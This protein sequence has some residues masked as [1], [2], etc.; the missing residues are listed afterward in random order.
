MPPKPK[1]PALPS[2]TQQVAEVLAT[3]TKAI[4][5]IV[6]STPESK[7]PIQKLIVTFLANPTI[8]ELH[9]SAQ[10]PAPSKSPLPSLLEDIK[11]IKST[12]ATLQKVILPSA[13]TG[14]PP[15][16]KTTDNAPS[17]PITGAKGKT[18]IPT[19][20][21]AAA[22]PPHPSIVVSLHNLIWN[23]GRPSPA[24]LCTRINGALKPQPSGNDQ[25]HISTTRW[26]VRENV[27][28]TGG[29][30]T[31]AQHLQQAALTISQY[32]SDTYPL[33]PQVLPLLDQ[34]IPIGVSTDC[35]ARMPDECHAV[36]VLDNPSYASLNITQKPSW[37]CNPNSYPEGAVSSLV[38]VFEH[39]DSS[40]ARDL[41]TK[42]V[43]Y[44]FGHCATLRKWKQRPTTLTPQ[45][46]HANSTPKP[47]ST[48]DKEKELLSAIFKLAIEDTNT[49]CSEGPETS[50][51]T[52]DD[53]GRQKVGGGKGRDRP[54]RT[55]C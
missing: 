12:L 38:V 10:T 14:K 20:A 51:N 50:K 3:V 23:K 44:M 1:P 7:E 16:S 39:P 48:K 27:I 15:P 35:R 17:A 19:F 49:P 11:S 45:P 13:K 53:D 52:K 6:S 18:H 2:N 21:R 34:I 33:P 36:L 46:E 25:V 54:T 55:P 26:T 42:K 43:L 5:D 31:S 24:D 28:L 30:N 47:T 4:E 32:L 40:L 9:G 22:S 29:P 41:L 8:A 37:V